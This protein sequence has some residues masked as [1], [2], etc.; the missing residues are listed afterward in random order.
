M[1]RSGPSLPFSYCCG[2]RRLRLP[3]GFVTRPQEDCRA[4]LLDLI[5]NE[6]QGID[7]GFWFMEDDRYAAELI[8]RARTGVPVRVLV[9]SARTEP[10]QH[11]DPRSTRSRRHSDSPADRPRHFPL[12]NDVARGPAHRRVQRRELFADGLCSDRAVRNYIDEA[13][14]FSDDPPIVQSFMSGRRSLDGHNVVRRLRS[15]SGAPSRRY[16]LYAVDPI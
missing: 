9:R 4:I 10:H 16:P 2:L 1:Y 15:I 5:R 11:A 13:I 8:R 14:F 3:S 7:V 12:E 6:R